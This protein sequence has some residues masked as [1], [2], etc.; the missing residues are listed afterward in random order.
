MCPFAVC[1]FYKKH[2]FKLKE[3][4]G[5]KNN[6]LVFRFK[7]LNKYHIKHIPPEMIL[8]DLLDF[9]HRVWFSTDLWH[10]TEVIRSLRLQGITTSFLWSFRFFF[11]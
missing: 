6:K 1:C 10:F 8:I 5:Y 9:Y 2:L 11:K 4:G 3:C 7:V